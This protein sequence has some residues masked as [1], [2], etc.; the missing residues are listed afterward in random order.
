MVVLHVNITIKNYE[1]GYV[2]LSVLLVRK[3]DN[4]LNKYFHFPLPLK[5]FSFEY[6]PTLPSVL[7]LMLSVLH[8]TI[9]KLKSNIHFK[10]KVSVGGMEKF[11]S[12]KIKRQKCR[13]A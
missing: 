4:S 6:R 7:F 10:P 5:S 13:Y 8:T 11:S 1:N 3:S 2:C 12:A 9:A